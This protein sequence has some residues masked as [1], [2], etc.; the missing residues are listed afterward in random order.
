[1]KEKQDIIDMVIVRGLSVIRK[2]NLPNDQ[3][4]KHID[5]KDMGIVIYTPLSISE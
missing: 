1:M 2:D 4:H 5:I 3:Y